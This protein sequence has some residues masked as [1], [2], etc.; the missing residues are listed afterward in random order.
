[1]K[2][3]VFPILLWIGMTTIITAQTAKREQEIL[4]SLNCLFEQIY[5]LENVVI[6]GTRTTPIIESK[7][8]TLVFNVQNSVSSQG[9][10]ALELLKRTPGVFV[11]GNNSISINGRNGVL[12]LL[13]GKQT[14]LPPTEL[15]TYLQSLPAASILKIEVM[16]NPSAEYE[17]AGSAGIL[18][19]TLVKD[20]SS[21]FNGSLNNGLSYWK[22]IK[23]NT[24]FSFNNQKGRWNIFGSYNHNYGYY[25]YDY[26][27]E[28]EQNDRQYNSTSY[29]DDKR[30][31]T[32]ISIGTDFQL[33]AH[34]TFG[35]LLNANFYFG[36]GHIDTQTAIYQLDTGK[37]LK[38]LQSESYYYHQHSNRYSANLNYRW[39]TDQQKLSVDADYG[40]FDGRNASLQ[41]NIYYS[42][43]GEEIERNCYRAINSRNIPMLALSVHFETF[44]G[45]GQLKAGVKFSSISANNAYDLY[46]VTEKSEIN[47]LNRSNTFTYNEKLTSEYLQ[48][49]L[50]IHRKLQLYAGFRIEHTHTNSQLQPPQG[51]TQ[52]NR[53][54]KN[55]YT[56]LFP[57]AAF[58]YHLGEQ[59][60]LSISYGKRIDRPA[61]QDLNPFELPL[62]ELSCW[63]GNP[64]LQPQHTHRIAL[65]YQYY[66]TIIEATFSKTN[67]Y[68]SEITD[69]LNQTNIVMIPKN[70]GKQHYFGLMAMQSLTPLN[71][72]NIA[73]TATAHYIDRNIA[74]DSDRPISSKRWGGSFSIRTDAR[75][76]LG[77]KAEVIGIF[78]TA[79]LGGSNDIMTPNSQINLA[80]QK[81][82]LNN[83]FTVRLT[84]TDIYHNNN[85]N[86]TGGYNN[87]KLC[88]WGI[89]ESRQIKINFT[90]KFGNSKKENTGRNTGLE[91]ENERL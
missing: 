56:N 4:D 52:T 90:Y 7:G 86:S 32:Y 27:S 18:N 88:S 38:I 24:E 5:E 30:N 21:G 36:P 6:V 14:Y 58:T 12:V 42:V 26:S 78:N 79:R 87:F 50:H 81:S 68:F 48:Y 23:Q 1:M 73:L 65:N 39:Q 20:N 33:N 51:S 69:S 15:G 83:H 19:I 16:S 22:S 45:K 43:Y 9:S 47:D 91:N 72:W 10:N 35:A 40:Y 62:N 74:F 31:S 2:K 37:L 28:R 61:Y 77:I 3:Y 76:F 70:L 44:L 53:I 71:G 17:A 41:P 46:N 63:K 84:C 64:F 11:D 60:D 80:F 54:N 82:F 13:N 66:K 59:H 49:H 57:S 29:D 55:N 85:W 89:G 25:H 75:L 67:N 34:H 8:G